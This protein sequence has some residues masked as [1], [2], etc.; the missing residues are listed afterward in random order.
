MA[1]RSVVAAALLL[2]AGCKKAEDSA[3]PVEAT[4]KAAD[5]DADEA[6]EDD[7]EEE[8]SPYL[9]ASNFNRKIEE[10]IGQFVG[11]WQSTAGKE[12]DP[13]TGR[14]RT[15]VVVGGQGDVAKVMF[16]DQRSDLKHPA[17]YA[18]ITEKVK[19]LKFNISL[20]G[21][22]T[23]MPYTFDLRRGELLPE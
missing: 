5:A 21:G 14:V 15:T 8:E 23:P 12:A 7:D 13:P 6:D 3:P 16:D 17:L 10:N 9:D 18:C 11:C 20:T 1:L 22:E 2:L 4:A 19:A